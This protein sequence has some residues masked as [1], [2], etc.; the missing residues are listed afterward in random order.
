[1]KRKRLLLLLA[2]LMTAATGAWA[3]D[4]KHRITATLNFSSQTKPKTLDVTLPYETTIGAVYT[5]ITDGVTMSGL[6]LSAAEVTSGTNVSIGELNGWNTPVNVTADGN[7][8][9]EFTATLAGNN[10]NGTIANGIPFGIYVYSQAINTSEA[11]E[12]A[13][14]AISIAN[15]YKGKVALPIVI[16]TEYTDA[17][18]NGQR[19]GRADYLSRFTRTDIVKAFVERVSAAGYEPMIYASKSFLMNNLNMNQLS[20]Y[21]LW[22]AQYYDYCTYP[23]TSN[24]FMWQYTSSGSIAGSSAR[25]DISVMY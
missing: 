7:A 4:T 24:I 8:T 16:D 11:I 14:R 10:I 12:E 19:I 5:A 25:T 9:V 3:Q 15:Q 6:S 2:L 17:W 13:D 18:E 22:V 21:K 20:N 1:M 23:D